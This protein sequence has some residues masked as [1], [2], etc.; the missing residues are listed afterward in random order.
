M[1]RDYPYMQSVKNL[2]L[3][4]EKIK[5]AQTPPKFTYD[6]LSTHLGYPSS[7]DRS[8]I[9][10]LKNLGFL[11]PDSSPTERYNN[12]RTE[13]LSKS[14]MAEGLREGW[15]DIFL[16]DSY[17]Y[18]RTPSELKEIFKNVTGKSESVAEKM[19]TTFY[20]L[21]KLADFSKTDTLNVKS[22]EKPL[23]QEQESING[24][25]KPSL[26]LHND[27]HLHLPATSDVAVYKAIFRAIKEELID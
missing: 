3:I 27:I 21:I 1:A 12:F 19:S 25:E 11:K 17:A 5:I 16:A 2:K 13:G 7:N 18:K 14:S 15:S 10:I 6:F 26:N 9:R 24:V 20:T 23:E 22:E 4:F 8:L